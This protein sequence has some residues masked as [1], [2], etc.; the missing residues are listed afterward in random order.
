MNEKAIFP[1]FITTE[2]STNLSSHIL[3]KYDVLMNCHNR[4][5]N[6]SVTLTT[7]ARRRKNKAFRTEVI[8]SRQ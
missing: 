6:G 5:E 7:S 1:K 3:A 8:Y 2:D 4:R